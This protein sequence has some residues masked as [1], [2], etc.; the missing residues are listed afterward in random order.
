MFAA[1]I[2]LL[3]LLPC[4]FFS[5]ESWSL[6]ASF[7]F[8]FIVL[9]TSASISLGCYWDE[10]RVRVLA[11]FQHSRW[12][13]IV[14]R[15]LQHVRI[16]AYNISCTSSSIRSRIRMPPIFFVLCFLILFLDPPFFPTSCHTRSR[17][18]R[19]LANLSLSS[20]RNHSFILLLASFTLYI[21]IVVIEP[22]QSR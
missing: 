10:V 14:S 8:F 4:L 12:G 9:V 21:P 7:F 17:L 19:S 16:A 15:R 11:Y 1:I 5:A 3:I 6:A 22:L 13:S 20:I 2:G 18:I